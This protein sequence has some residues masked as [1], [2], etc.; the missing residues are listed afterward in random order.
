MRSVAK[1]LSIAVILLLSQ[2]LAPISLQP[3]D[4]SWSGNKWCNVSTVYVWDQ[5]GQAQATSL[6]LWGWNAQPISIQFGIGS[7]SNW[8]IKV[9]HAN[10]GAN[11]IP[12]QVQ[13]VSSGGCFVSG[14]I[15]IELNDYYMNQY[16]TFRKENTI[17]HEMGHTLGLNDISSQTGT[18]ALMLS[19][20]SWDTW[21]IIVGVYDDV[22]ILQIVYG[23]TSQP[24]LSSSS[25]GATITSLPY[26]PIT[27]KITSPGGGK[28]GFVY[29]SSRSST[30]S[31]NIAIVTT[32]AYSTTL[33]RFSDGY[34]TSTNPGD[35]TK[36]VGTIELDNDGI[37]LIA[38]NPSGGLSFV[39]LK[40]SSP[41]TGSS[42]TYWLE[43]VLQK[44]DGVTSVWAYVVKIST[45]TMYGGLNNNMLS[46]SQLKYNYNTSPLK[47]GSG[48]WTDSSSNP[49]PDYTLTKFW[50]YSP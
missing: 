24:S 35:G 12:A 34:Y 16:T 21:G 14:Q 18:P 49:A 37:K 48:I 9:T 50:D 27:L 41:G 33:Y 8:D 26:P 4:A 6:S 42:N 5:S 45:N 20:G 17:G 1:V 22:N 47:F 2:L 46:G 23:S 25:N 19:P 15:I 3:V 31:H 40:N 44:A 11:G 13:L 10:R 32:K 38:T 29:D 7:S 43:V 30:G 28:Y 36:R 39:T